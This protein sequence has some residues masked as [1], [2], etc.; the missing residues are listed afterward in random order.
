MHRLGLGLIWA[1][2]VTLSGLLTVSQFG[3]SQ[4]FNFFLNLNFVC[5]LVLRTDPDPDSDPQ[6][7]IEIKII[8]TSINHLINPFRKK[9][10]FHVNIL[11]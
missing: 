5:E 1:A 7:V 10:P 8:V 9:N 11:N 2:S 4:D 3:F 6:M